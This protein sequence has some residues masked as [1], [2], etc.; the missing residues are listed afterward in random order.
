[1]NSPETCMLAHKSCRKQSQDLCLGEIP[2]QAD[3]KKP[4]LKLGLG[5]KF[6]SAAFL[7]H[8]HSGEKIKP[9][10]PVYLFFID[11]DRYRT[12][13]I[14]QQKLQGYKDVGEFPKFQPVQTRKYRF[15]SEVWLRPTSTRANLEGESMECIQAVTL[16]EIPSPLAKS[17][18][19]PVGI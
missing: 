2:Y 6:Y 5:T 8:V 19:E 15:P 3:V 13:L 11:P 14:T 7:F 18:P 16:E 12:T 4:V 1:M 9:G 10:Q 17:F